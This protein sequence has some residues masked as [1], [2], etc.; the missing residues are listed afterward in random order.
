[1]ENITQEVI[2]GE[3]GTLHSLKK[4]IANIR[5]RKEVLVRSRVNR[6]IT[7]AGANPG[8]VLPSKRLL[9]I[10][11]WMGSHFHN[12]TGYNGVT[13]LVEL[14]EWGRKFSGFLG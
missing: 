5:T 13:F 1:M 14:L 11:R 8:G 9:G 4:K 6:K 7:T 12:W 2:N 10:W 3:R